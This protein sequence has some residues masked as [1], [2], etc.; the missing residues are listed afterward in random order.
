MN[1]KNAVRISTKTL[2][3]ITTQPF[4][5]GDPIIVHAISYINLTNITDEVLLTDIDGNDI[6][7]LQAPSYVMTDIIWLADNGL[8]A[9]A[10]SVGS[11]GFAIQHTVTVVFSR[12]G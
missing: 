1:T 8:V 9:P 5:N 2:N 6:I 4:A 11:E 3:G 7:R 10:D 12:T